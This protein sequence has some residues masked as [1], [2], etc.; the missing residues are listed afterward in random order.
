MWSPMGSFSRGERWFQA[1][2]GDSEECSL[3]TGHPLPKDSWGWHMWRIWV[4]E[5][6]SG[7]GE[8]RMPSLKLHFFNPAEICFL[9]GWGEIIAQ[10]TAAPQNVNLSAALRG[11]L[12]LLPSGLQASPLRDNL[13][14]IRVE[15]MDYPV[16]SWQADCSRWSEGCP[17]RQQPP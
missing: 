14:T 7:S 15:L 4:G 13:L 10:W 17:A 5:K 11:W 2:A 1:V 6:K 12:I 9:K 8:G 3:G 16:P